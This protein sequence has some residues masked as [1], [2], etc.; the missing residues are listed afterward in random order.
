M[1][2]LLISRFA[3]ILFPQVHLPDPIPI[4]SGS[5]TQTFRNLA[6]GETEREIVWRDEMPEW[7]IR[8]RREREWPNGLKI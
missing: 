6:T 1:K 3:P 8:E 2:G 7:W 5:A 4:F